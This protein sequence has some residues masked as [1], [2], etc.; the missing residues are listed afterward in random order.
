MNTNASL[1]PRRE[2]FSGVICGTSAF[3]IWGLSP[4]FWKVLAGV[5]AFELLMHRVVWSFL[6]L[7]VL[8]IVQGRWDQFSAAV[9]HRKTLLVLFVTT[10]FVSCNWFLYIWSVNNGYVL[11]ASL[12]YY[13]NPLVNV[14]LGVIVLRER[15]RP[16]Q[17]LA[18]MLAGVG[19]VYLTVSYGVFPWISLTLALTFGVYGLLRKVSP[20]GSLEGLCVETLIISVPA[21]VYLVAIDID[22][23]GAF[24]SISIKTDIFLAGT[25][26]LTGL[27][28]LLFNLGA[29]RLNLSTVGFLQYLAPSTMF[30]LAIFV[31]HEPISKAQI[32]S[33]GF[34]WAALGI[35]STDTAL[36]YGRSE[37]AGKAS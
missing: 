37:T 1:N 5:P 3:L 17:L 32:V 25:A 19:V 6:F 22:G 31:F 12:G 28:L 30:V 23:S 18:V 16:L 36:H 15:L 26:L 8:L 20:V 4:L 2:A 10:L 34:V 11:Q 9:T 13:I 24:M 29:K 27:P 14:V 33:F 7:A 35:Y 21:L